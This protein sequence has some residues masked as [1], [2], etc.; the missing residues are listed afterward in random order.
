MNKS[1][2]IK[3]FI[4]AI[5]FL[6]LVAT[7]GG[8]GTFYS[9]AKSRS[10]ATKILPAISHLALANQYR[11]QAFLHLMRAI[12]SKDAAAF[13]IQEQQ[14]QRSSDLSY[15]EFNLYEDS[16]QSQENRNLYNN[17]IQERDN[18]IDC[19]KDILLLAKSGN[20]AEANAQL[21]QGLLPL[22]ENY[23]NKGQALVN[24]ATTDANEQLHTIRIISIISQAFAIISSVLIFVFGFMLGYTR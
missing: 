4:V 10:I 2:H 7:I 20:M 12:N 9:F 14:I 11:G 8:L 16:I 5:I 18:Y 13:T 24:Y 23:L 22:Y 15:N 17:L 3:P 21:L 6:M 19:R 1:K